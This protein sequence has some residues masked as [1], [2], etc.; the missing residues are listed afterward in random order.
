MTGFKRTAATVVTGAIAM[1]GVA[2]P[3]GAFADDYTS[4]PPSVPKGPDPQVLAR[5][6]QA[7][8]KGDSLPFTGA[9][10]AQMA[11]IGAGAVLVGTVAV[12]RARRSETRPA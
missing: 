8:P 10:V 12:R 1:L 6:F 2:M 11:A 5:Q 7:P 9:D 4:P 3:A